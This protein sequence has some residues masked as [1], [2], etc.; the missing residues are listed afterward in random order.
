MAELVLFLAVVVLPVVCLILYLVS[1]RGG[2]RFKQTGHLAV[3]CLPWILIAVGLA[4]GSYIRFY[5]HRS[6]TSPG[7]SREL[8][9]TLVVS[10]GV[11]AFLS[12]TFLPFLWIGWLVIRIRARLWSRLMWCINLF[13]WGYAALLVL[14]LTDAWLIL[15]AP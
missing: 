9:D 7:D 11:V 3:S 6:G 12:L 14:F 4:V 2:A 10:F 13:W 8:S 1:S 5:S 15:A